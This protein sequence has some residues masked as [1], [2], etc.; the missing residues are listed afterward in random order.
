MRFVLTLTNKKY[1]YKDEFGNCLNIDNLHKNLLG[2][3][4]RFSPLYLQLSWELADFLILDSVYEASDDLKKMILLVQDEL[5]NFLKSKGLKNDEKN[6]LKNTIYKIKILNFTDELVPA[7]KLLA[8]Y[9]VYSLSSAF[10]KPFWFE[11]RYIKGNPSY[12]N[13]SVLNDWLKNID[14]LNIYLENNENTPVADN[15]WKKIFLKILN[16]FSERAFLEIKLEKGLNTTQH[17]YKFKFHLSRVFNPFD[18]GFYLFKPQYFFHCGKTYIQGLTFLS[19]DVVNK[20]NEG[21]LKFFQPGTPDIL[22]KL[23]S[24]KLFLDNNIF[25]KIKEVLCNE[26]GNLGVKFEELEALYFNYNFYVKNKI[27]INEIYRYL[28]FLKLD[29]FKDCLKDGFYFSYYFDFRG[30]IY[31]RGYASPQTTHIFR[32][33]YHY[34]A[35]LKPTFPKN[36]K[37]ID[38]KPF[39]TYIKKNTNIDFNYPFLKSLNVDYA[40]FWL[41]I[42][43]GKIGKSEKLSETK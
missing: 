4:G 43:L 10:I 22:D 35:Y 29:D 21:S 27:E 12:Y 40:L 32:F 5:Q 13:Y 34:G 14:K 3:V 20:Q 8:T 7:E 26:M 28:S 16:I 31:Y 9:I 33:C 24:K 37:L 41:F 19:L 18:F 30:R 42:E 38:I 15:I 1:N 23:I 17:F 36:S 2:G 6:Y 25:K 11:H 39:I